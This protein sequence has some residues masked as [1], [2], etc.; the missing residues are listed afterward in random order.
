MIKSAAVGLAFVV[1]LVAGASSV[2]AAQ[3]PGAPQKHKVTLFDIKEQCALENGGSSTK[4]ADGKRHYTMP[5]SNTG[6][7]GRW[8]KCVADRRAAAGV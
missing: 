1:A 3:R 5:N 2:D 7:F 6:P 4:T 8:V